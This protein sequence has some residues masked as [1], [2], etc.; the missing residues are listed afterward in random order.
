MELY[1]KSV[2][3]VL[4]LVGS[5]EDGLSQDEAQRRLEKNGY[6]EIKDREKVPTWRLFLDT[7]KDPMVIVLLIAAGVQL[8]LGEIVESLIILLVLILN[9]IIS[10]VQSKKAE[11]S[12]D[13]LR[14]LSA[15]EAKVLR[16]GAT[17]KI[18]AREVVPGDIVLLEA[19]DYVPADGR[20]INS[21]SLKV[22]EGMLT[23]ESE[24]VEKNTLTIS[25][26]VGLGDRINMAY[27]GSLV[28][29]G[30]GRLVV[31]ETA[32]KTEMGKIADM[33]ASAEEKQTP[34]QRKLDAFSKKLGIIILVLSVFIFLLQAARIWLGGA[35]VDT[36][37]AL[38]NAL[39]FAVAV[40]VAAIP[41]ALSAIVTIV[42][43][44]GTNKMAKQHAIIRKLYAVETLG[45]TSIIATDKTGTL[46]QNKMTVTDYFIPGGSLD[47][48]SLDP[49]PEKWNPSERRLV[50]IAVLC[51]DSY[52][53][54]EGKE[55]G[56]PTEVAL[57]HFADKNNKNYKE[58]RQTYPR[59]TELPFDSDRKLMS[60]VHMIDNQ[61]IMFTKGGPD[62]MFARAKYVLIDGQEHELTEDRLDQFRRANENFSNQALRVLA[63]GYKRLSEEQNAIDEN[64]E[65]DL[66]LVGLTAMIDPPREEVYDAIRHA[67]S[68]GIKP[69]MIT[70]DHKTTA[71]AIG[72]D[73]G[74]M[75]EKDIALS[76]TE[77][78][79]MSDQEL[80]QKL[81]HISVY[82][83]VSPENKIRIVRAWQRKEKVTAMT[84]DGV[85]DAPALKQADIGI[86]MG[87]GTDVAKDAAAMILTDDNFATIVRAVSVGRTVYD[88]IKKAISY[89][90]AGNL[91]AIIAILYAVILNLPNPFTALQL[92]Y[93]NL[94]NDS[95]PAIALGM[96]K[97]EPN[98]M[99]R[100]PR[101]PEE[102]LFG[103]GTLQ[104]V[105]I[106]G[107]LIGITVIISF[108]IGLSY[109][110]QMGV[111]MAFTTLILSRT[112]QTFA[113]RSNTQTSIQAGFFGNRYVIGAVLL[114]F[115]FYGIT[116]LPGVRDIFDIP[117]EFG[118]NQWLIATGLSLLSVVLMEVIKAI[119]I[120]MQKVQ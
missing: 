20:I 86:A 87:S 75:D 54:K 17:Q 12:L 91:G 94:V 35:A 116:V 37:T 46:T 76:G 90:F 21:A 51:N 72:R 55:I 78:D 9:S 100:K 11:S 77:L 99:K 119:R 83:R 23:G 110:T 43:S 65:Y 102:G 5:S 80:D 68:A 33:L 48:N 64:D 69:V 7:F 66:V 25:E 38:L 79:A 98:V 52:I 26:E 118:W 45:S 82:A 10:V 44:V 95:L 96:E 106:R 89:L 58:L 71:Q 60:T 81:E 61:K 24:A 50:Q 67:K 85:N 109:S 2:E 70:G 107:L 8:V 15:P 34:L 63:Y 101:D 1:R 53:N 74:L 93:I 97:S 42:L 40:A 4:D 105:I 6:N 120:R 39:M 19:G 3:E 84:G 104:A 41:E 115:L 30:N 62:V 112:L 13:A 113:A 18:P 108:Y 14:N 31:T 114:G 117:A 27:S 59:E 103:G 111:A 36:G 92:L 16:N 47:Q 56:D 57:I 73:I 88:N 32:E 28:V 29:H 22:N 49:N